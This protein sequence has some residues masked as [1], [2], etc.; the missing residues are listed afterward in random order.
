MNK[1]IW[2]VS[3]RHSDYVWE[4]P[5]AA[6]W[7]VLLDP[8][9]DDYTPDEKSAEEL[10]LL[11]A[12]KVKADEANDLVPIY[13]YVKGEG[14]FEYMPFQYEHHPET[15]PDN[16][17]T[18]HSWPVDVETAEPLN[19]LSLPVVDK[20]WRPGSAAKGGFIQE[21]TGWKP[22]ILQPFVFL[23]SLLRGRGPGL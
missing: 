16:F 7:E 15:H 6:Y 19:W 2:R 11:W 23:P 12:S 5:L 4:S 1:K 9:S 10:L 3:S 20:L 14:Q 17:L 22:S 21:A 8:I 18:F 13:W